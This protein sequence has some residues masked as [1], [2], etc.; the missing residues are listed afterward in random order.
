MIISPPQNGKRPESSI[1]YFVEQFQVREGGV[2]L[3]YIYIIGQT[4]MACWAVPFHGESQ[5]RGVLVM[6]EK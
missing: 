5:W 2:K 6:S 4:V 1:F 3:F